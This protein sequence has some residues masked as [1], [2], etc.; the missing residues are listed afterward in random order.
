MTAFNFS[1]PPKIE[2]E[3][4]GDEVLVSFDSDTLGFAKSTD[5][6][7]IT[8]DWND[9]HFSL[10]VYENSVL[11]EL[12][13]DGDGE[14]LGVGDLP[15]EAFV[16]DIYSAVRG[17]EGA[18]LIP[19]SSLE[20]D[21]LY[22][23][24]LD[25]ARSYL[26]D[27]GVVDEEGGLTVNPEAWE[28]TERDIISH[29]PETIRFLDRTFDPIPLEEVRESGEVVFFNVHPSLNYLH[30]V[31]LMPGDYVEVVH[32]FDL[33]DALSDL[34]GSPLMHYLN[35]SLENDDF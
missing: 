27:R 2:V 20:M 4:R 25:G 8:N 33:A 22:Q 14:N 16:A 10:S 24:D 35:R 13:S 19:I 7:Q 3:D 32:L 21:Y 28:D 15:P 23:L 11:Y 34:G 12:S 9:H 26:S 18:K 29:R 31:L 17:I 1:E 6:F 5:G 30:V